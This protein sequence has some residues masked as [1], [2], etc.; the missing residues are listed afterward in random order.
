[1]SMFPIASTTVG[2]GGASSIT[3]SSIPQNF[4]HLQL[5]FFARST[6][7]GAGGNM[8]V[9]YNGDGGNNYTWHNVGGDGGSA[10]SASIGASNTSANFGW[11]AGNNQTSGVFGVGIVDILDYTNTNKYKVSRSLNGIDNN[12]SGLT[13][14]WSGLWL[15]TAAITS[16]YVNVNGFAQYSTVQLYGITTA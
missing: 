6:G 10:F 13:G 11:N 7:N 15:S 8:S 3:F 14:I 16:I 4:T 9:N 2:S 1:M 5:R 12:G